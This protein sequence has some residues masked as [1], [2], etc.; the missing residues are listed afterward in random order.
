MTHS[1]PTPPHPTEY[2][3]AV[4]NY[5]RLVPAGDIVATLAVQ[6][7]LLARHVGSLSDEQALVHHP[8]FTWSIKQVVGHMADCERVFG[9]RAMRL[10]RQDATPLPGFDENAYMAPADFDRCPLA[11]L[12]AE[13]E[14]LRKSNVLMF[15]QLDSPAWRYQG[16]V[17]GNPMTTRTVAWVMAGHAQ[18]HLAILEKRLA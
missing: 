12:L 1:P 15:R 17:N 10:A 18:H 4:E 5:V 6:P 3:P 7:E 16:I 2:S 13:F 14:L 11:E 9:Y 8:P